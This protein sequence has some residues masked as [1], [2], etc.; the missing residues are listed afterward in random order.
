[1]SNASLV[2]DQVFIDRRDESNV[3]STNNV[4]V[5]DGYELRNWQNIIWD[6]YDYGVT[7]LATGAIG[8]FPSS[9]NGFDIYD[10]DFGS[11]HEIISG[12]DAYFISASDGSI[13]P[14]P[15]SRLTFSDNSLSINLGGRGLAS[16]PL[17]IDISTT[18]QVTPS[19][20]P[21]P[22][23]AWLFLSA[24]GGI[25]WMTKIRGKKKI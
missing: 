16:S 24:I 7:L 3:I 4:V 21:L 19:P 12:V 17:Y 23:A 9:F 5:A 8:Y 6:F 10:L 20:V 1:M 2:G 11:E 22:A 15:E 25:G 13:N 18:D 14:L